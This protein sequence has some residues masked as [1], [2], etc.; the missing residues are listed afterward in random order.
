MK[1]M[2]VLFGIVLPT[3]AAGSMMMIMESTEIV[4]RSL[5]CPLPNGAQVCIQ[6]CWEEPVSYAVPVGPMR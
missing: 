1:R 4:C 5:C 2:L 3:L 6:F